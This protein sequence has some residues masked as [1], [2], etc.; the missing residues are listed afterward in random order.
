MSSRAHASNHRIPFSLK[1]VPKGA[2]IYT[3][4]QLQPMDDKGGQHIKPI[5]FTEEELKVLKMV[6]ERDEET[7]E[8]VN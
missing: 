2:N 6:M 3:L 4:G 1:R 7:G 8:W 5:P